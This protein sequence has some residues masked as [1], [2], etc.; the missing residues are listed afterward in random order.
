M[1]STLSYALLL[2]TVLW[3]LETAL[4][5][6]SAARQRRFSLTEL[7]RHFGKWLLWVTILFVAY[8]L[9]RVDPVLDMLCKSMQV[10]VLL[11]Q[12][13]YVLRG[14]T[15]LLD[16]PLADKILR[17][18]QGRI[19]QRLQVILDDLSTARALADQAHRESQ[20]L[21]VVTNQL[22]ADKNQVEERLTLLEA[23]YAA[24]E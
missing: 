18:F 12:A 20:Q 22:Q 3:F 10:S 19:E 17:V 5:L 13:L 21:R 9:S 14:A 7:A 24:I 16:N 1:G 6:C 2:T 11:T 15:A 4:N 23:P 8:S